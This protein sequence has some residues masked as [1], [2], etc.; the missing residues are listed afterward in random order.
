MK[1]YAGVNLLLRLS[2]RDP[3][4]GDIAVICPTITPGWGYSGH[5]IRHC[6]SDHPM[7]N[8]GLR[9]G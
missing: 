7:G 5:Y 2:P 1:C 4:D 3:R 6:A 9:W 8:R